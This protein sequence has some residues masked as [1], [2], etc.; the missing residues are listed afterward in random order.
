VRPKAGSPDL[1]CGCGYQ[2]LLKKLSNIARRA[3][4]RALH[5]AIIMLAIVPWILS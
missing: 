2:S 5:A 3:V 4:S 1:P